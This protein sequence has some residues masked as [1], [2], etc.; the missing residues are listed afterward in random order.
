ME[1]LSK[2]FEKFLAILTIVHM[3]VSIARLDFKGEFLQFF[4]NVG[5]FVAHLVSLGSLI[6]L[7]EFLGT[8]G[9]HVLLT[10][11]G[12]MIFL[13]GRL[14]VGRLV[15]MFVTDHYFALVIVVCVVFVDLILIVKLPLIILLAPSACVGCVGSFIICH[16]MIGVTSNSCITSLL[17]KPLRCWAN[18]PSDKVAGRCERFHHVLVQWPSRKFLDFSN[19]AF[20]IELVLVDILK[21]LDQ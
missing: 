20:A 10:C 18:I 7:K 3:T 11:H 2:L 13:I 6:E 12:R 16:V 21:S 14:R 9:N 4:A 8:N 17:P 19:Y 5:C 15:T 1:E